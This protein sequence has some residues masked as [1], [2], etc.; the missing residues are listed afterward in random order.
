MEYLCVS[1]SLEAECDDEGLNEAEFEAVSTPS[2]ATTD[3][4]RIVACQFARY[5]TFV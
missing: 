4:R 5:C 2:I 1:K 3:H